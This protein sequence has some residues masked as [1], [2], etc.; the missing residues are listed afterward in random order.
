MAGS[1]INSRTTAGAGGGGA[2]GGGDGDADVAGGDVAGVAVA[3]DGGCA[4]GGSAAG[5]TGA[6]GA[7]CCVGGVAPCATGDGSATRFEAGQPAQTMAMV[8][9]RATLANTARAGR[10]V[11]AALTV[12]SSA[13]T[14]TAAWLTGC[15]ATLPPSR[16]V[17][18]FR[19]S[20]VHRAWLPQ[21][22]PMTRRMRGVPSPYHSPPTLHAAPQTPPP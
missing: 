22:H 5:V 17:C 4:A 21:H 8:S 1:W 10:R 14:W 9:M 3:G 12:T 11:C 6:V 16:A 20:S 2:S 13:V 19:P 7:A 15:A 18:P